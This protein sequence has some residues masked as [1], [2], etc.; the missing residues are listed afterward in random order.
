MYRRG[1][2]PGRDFPR[3]SLLI[4]LVCALWSPQ[5][6]CAS[7]ALTL[8]IPVESRF[9]SD[10]DGWTPNEAGTLTWAPDGD[11]SGGFALFE[12]LGVGT[13][14]IIAPREY[15]GDW[16]LLDGNGAIS[17]YHR[18]VRYGG[19][20]Q[21]VP[22]A[23]R[24]TGPGGVATWT[25]PIVPDSAW[26][27][28]SAPINGGEWTVE[29]GSW[30]AIL[31]NVT[32]LAIQAELVDNSVLP[33]DQDGIDSIRLAGSDPVSVNEFADLSKLRVH[34]NPARR[35]ARLLISGPGGICRVSFFDARGGIVH[36]MTVAQPG[37]ILF[38]D[39]AEQ[40]AQLPIG[41]YF[42]RVETS[43]RVM[44]TKVLLQP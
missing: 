24:L 34:P 19:V 33:L 8:E 12:D 29:S 16:T 35:D 13:G 40:R 26:T 10:L 9:D 3:L 15:L 11:W 31:A 17:W 2:W 7:Q 1:Q 42:I 18:I 27:Y 38:V 14:R 43:T 23:A 41:I 22:P 28:V 21:V 32:E 25:A 36:R 4:L 5:V 39:L 44:T 6:P 37:S 30:S 20:Y